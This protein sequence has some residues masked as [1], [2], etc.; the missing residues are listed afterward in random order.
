M[1]S[2]PASPLLKADEFTSASEVALAT[3]AAPTYF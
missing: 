3:A 1:F 2:E